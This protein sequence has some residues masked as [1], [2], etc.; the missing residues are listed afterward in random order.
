MIFFLKNLLGHGFAEYQSICGNGNL[1]PFGHLDGIILPVFKEGNVNS[2]GLKKG[3]FHEV[4]DG[5]EYFTGRSGDS[6]EVACIGKDLEKQRL[7][8]LAVSPYI[9]NFIPAEFN[10]RNHYFSMVSR[11]I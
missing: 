1:S 3:C 8:V 5:L 10:F 6:Q 7:E 2:F 4:Q 11:Y 9:S